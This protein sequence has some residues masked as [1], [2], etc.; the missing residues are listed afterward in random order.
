MSLLRSCLW[1]QENQKLRI[2]TNEARRVN[3][4]ISPKFAIKPPPVQNGD[5]YSY[6]PQVPEEELEIL[7][8][9]DPKAAVED[10]SPAATAAAAQQVTHGSNPNSWTEKQDAMVRALVEE[11]GPG[12]WES[13]ASIFNDMA[14]SGIERSGSGLMN[15]WYLLKHGRQHSHSGGNAGL[16][17]LAASKSPLK[18]TGM[19]SPA[20]VSHHAR[21]DPIFEN[22]APKWSDSEDR[23]LA[24]LVSKYG[25]GDWKDKAKEFNKLHSWGQF[26][27]EES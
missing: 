22:G 11:N 20:H 8:S 12:N 7:T 5:P 18:Y 27:M 3:R 26:L 15:R 2:S 1:L 14:G 9:R 4:G 17:A 16:K 19:T 6:V 25:T 10:S 13:K 23:A 24:K 21:P